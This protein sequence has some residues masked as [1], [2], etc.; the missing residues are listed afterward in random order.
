[1]SN[2]ARPIPTTVMSALTVLAP[3][4]GATVVPQPALGIRLISPWTCPLF[5]HVVGN[6][7]AEHPTRTP[8][9]HTWP[10]KHVQALSLK[11]F[12][13]VW[14]G[15]GQRGQKSKGQ[16]EANDKRPMTGFESL[17]HRC[18]SGAQSH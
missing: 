10:S 8:A 5:C 1:M 9:A 17:V 12:L 3:L 6:P 7:H 16:A 18:R 14:G 2:R 11:L 13:R 4:C 15:G